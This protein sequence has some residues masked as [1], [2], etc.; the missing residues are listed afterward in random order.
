MRLL[1]G[2]A[3]APA[4]FERTM[5]I[6]LQGLDV[7]VS[8]IDDVL[9][10]GKTYGDHLC[11]LAKVIQQMKEYGLRVRNSGQLRT[12]TSTFVAAFYHI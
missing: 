8:Y 11:N 1:F 12:G 4:V 10:T 5:D 9:V 3:S 7:V 2:V 6:I